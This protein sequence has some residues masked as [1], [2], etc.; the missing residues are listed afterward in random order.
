MLDNPDLVVLISLASIPSPG[1]IKSKFITN[2]TK[3]DNR[4]GKYDHPI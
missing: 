2:E 1:H 4:L 3:V